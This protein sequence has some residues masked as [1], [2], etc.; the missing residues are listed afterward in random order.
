[1]A[2]PLWQLD[3]FQAH[4]SLGGGI[5][6]SIDLLEPASGLSLRTA[7]GQCVTAFALELPAVTAERAD[8]MLDAWARGADL[9]AT[10]A[11]R[12]PLHTRGQ[13]YF[14]AHRCDSASAST[15][16]LE[17]IA[18]AQTS[19]LDSEPGVIVRSRVPAREALLLSD[20]ASGNVSRIDLPPSGEPVLQTTGIACFL[21]PLAQEDITYVEMIHPADFSGCSL[22][23]LK[24]GE[25]ELATPLFRGRLE[26]GVILRSRLRALF[27]N[28]AGDTAIASK[29]FSEF[30]ASDPP[31]TV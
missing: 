15:P 10:Y 6:G 12:L 23:R 13:V 30:A 27:L 9:V 25:I 4:A 1:M 18:S 28:K 11:E 5:A 7:H 24:T 14:R 8:S 21:F 26:K 19:L 20:L 31:L 29:C 2:S 17:L 3:G 22:R 16:I